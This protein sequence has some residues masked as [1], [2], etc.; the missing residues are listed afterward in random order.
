MAVTTFRITMR[1]EGN[2]GGWS[3]SHSFQSS[4]STCRAVA[5]SSVCQNVVQSRAN[6]LGHGFFLNGFRITQI[7]GPD[8]NKI[9]RVGALIKSQYFAAV[10]VP[11][12]EMPVGVSLQ[13][14]D[15]LEISEKES[16]LG[17]IPSG[18]CTN[19]WIFNGNAA[20]FLTNVTSYATNLGLLGVG[21][22]AWAKNGARV[23]I[24]SYVNEPPTPPIFTVPMGALLPQVK[25][26]PQ[27]VRLQGLNG[28]N[29]DLNGEAL[30]Q[31]ID[32]Q[33]FSF[34]KAVASGPFISSGFVQL[35]TQPLPFVQASFI[36]SPSCAQHKRGNRS[37]HSAG[38]ARRRIRV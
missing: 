11:A 12:D 30:V 23:P 6:C 34:L 37:W 32:G 5:Q 20:N 1:F 3:E 14:K 29:C 35:Y 33:T 15:V 19:G 21:W 7:R 16:I 26:P 38:R 27:V 8:G 9:T 24:I 2:G 28:S 4:L 36:G 25:T 17:G 13:M 22:Q 10:D 31:V 18:V